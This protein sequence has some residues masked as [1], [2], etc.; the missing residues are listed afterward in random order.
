[1]GATLIVFSDD[2]DKALAS[3]VLANGAAATGKEVTMFFT[4]WGLSVIKR[5]ERVRAPKDFMGRMFGLMLPKHPGALSLSKMNFGGLGPA[6]MRGRMK[7]QNVDAIE[8]MIAAAKAA[9][10]R[11]VACQMSMD[12]MGVKREE[13]I[14]GVEIGG[15]A[16]YMEAAD[17]ANVNLFV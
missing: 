15:V 12:I 10:A 1:K 17:G 2:M 7:R 11:L 4:F 3:F 5:R 8:T 6:M 13:L 9:G 16:S 14:D